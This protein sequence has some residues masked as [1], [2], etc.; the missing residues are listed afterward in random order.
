MSGDRKANQHGRTGPPRADSGECFPTCHARARDEEA[1]GSD[2]GSMNLVCIQSEILKSIFRNRTSKQSSRGCVPTTSFRH[3]RARNAC[4]RRLRGRSLAILVPLVTPRHRV[5][6]RSFTVQP[7]MRRD[8]S[9]F[10][11]LMRFVARRLARDR[12]LRDRR[13]SP[14]RKPAAR[15]P[16]RRPA[17]RARCA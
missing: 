12:R 4:T 7:Q 14:S 2:E 13:P 5:A 10:A 11:S 15:A 8:E 1:L 16:R 9:S 17:A 3:R 6:L